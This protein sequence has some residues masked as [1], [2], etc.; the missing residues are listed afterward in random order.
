MHHTWFIFLSFYPSSKDLPKEDVREI[1]ESAEEL[2]RGKSSKC[3]STWC[4]RIRIKQQAGG[5]AVCKLNPGYSSSGQRPRQASCSSPTFAVL[6][7][8]PQTLFSGHSFTLFPAHPS[9][10]S[11]WLSESPSGLLFSQEGARWSLPSGLSPNTYSLALFTLK[12]LVEEDLAAW[13]PLKLSSKP[14]NGNRHHA[15][16]HTVLWMLKASHNP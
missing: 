9:L 16:S 8:L 12:L 3:F 1:A 4:M 5:K 10:R 13:I 2:N 15:T 7:L 11:E 6:E 14:V